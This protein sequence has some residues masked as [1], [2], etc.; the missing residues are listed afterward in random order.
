MVVIS[1]ATCLAVLHALGS[2]GI[3]TIAA[4]V[5]VG[6]LLKGITRLFGEKRDRALG[7]A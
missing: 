3:G 7:K 1:L 4:A 6:L 2:V 5:L